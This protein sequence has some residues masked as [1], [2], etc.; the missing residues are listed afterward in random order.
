MK[1]CL[2]LLSLA[3]SACTGA[4]VTANKTTPTGEKGSASTAPRLQGY[5]WLLSNAVDGETQRMNRL[6]GAS[7][8][9]LQVDFTDRS[10]I[11]RSCRTCNFD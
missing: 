6:F 10:L 7:A 11:E 9:A 4:A 2:L 3:L 1:A 5:H 8:K